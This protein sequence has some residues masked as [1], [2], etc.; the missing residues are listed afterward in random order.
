MIRSA[1]LDIEKFL[2]PVSAERPA[3]EPL[4]YEGTYDRIREAR[5]EDDPDLP[6][7]PWKTELRKAQWKLVE[8][9]CVEALETRS[10]QSAPR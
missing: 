6:Q 8:S 3:G 9:I 10:I 7:G 1:E 4:R 2:S 5:R